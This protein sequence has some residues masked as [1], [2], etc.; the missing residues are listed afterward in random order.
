MN[1]KFNWKEESIDLQNLL[2]DKENHRLKI[3]RDISPDKD[4]NEQQ[5]IL[6]NLIKNDN[7]LSLARQISMYGFVPVEKMIVLRQPKNKYIVLEGNRRLAA[8]KCLNDPSLAKKSGLT[9]DFK[10]LSD[11]SVI[12]QKIPV[13]VAPNRKEA[14]AKFIIPKHTEPS[15]EKWATYNKSKVYAKMVLEQQNKVDDICNTFNVQRDTIL[16]FLRMYQCYEI[17]KKLPLDGK[18]EG[19]V[20]NERKF[21]ITTLDRLIKFQE[22][23]K[24]LGITFDQ[25][26]KLK[27]KIKKAEFVKGYSKIIY[28][29]AKK[30]KTSRTLG[31]ID[32]IRIYI[33]EFKPNEKPNLKQKGNFNVDSF[34]NLKQPTIKSPK[35]F[36]ASKK[37]LYDYQFSIYIRSSIIDN[38]YTEIEKLNFYNKP[39]SFAIVFRTFLHICCLQYSRNTKIFLKIKKENKDDEDPTLGNYLNFFKDKNVFQD[40]GIKKS[41]GNFLSKQNRNMTTLNTLNQLNHGNTVVISGEQH[42]KMLDTLEQL[43]RKLLEGDKLS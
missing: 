8:L 42:S 40:N 32:T 27:G 38:I 34:R 16:E 33:K 1:N 21:P 24:F 4:K 26:G 37:T 13:F 12:T 39:Y 17:A 19:K 28:D 41:I 36:K 22:V 9:Q 29:L 43:L 14:L 10:E 15:V 3:E 5:I 35:K 2:L 30:D 20:K 11:S 6:E 25:N 7:I 18:I 23:Q 31:T